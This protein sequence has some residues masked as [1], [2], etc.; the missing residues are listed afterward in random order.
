MQEAKIFIGE[1][2]KVPEQ[3]KEQ[4]KEPEKPQSLAQELNTLEEPISETIVRP[5][6][7]SR[8]ESSGRS[9]TR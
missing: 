2:G 7:Q 4:A 3:K 1:E 9:A 5:R 8:C 6:S